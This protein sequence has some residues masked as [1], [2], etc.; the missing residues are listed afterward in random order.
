MRTIAFVR[1][2]GACDDALL[3]PVDMY[4]DAA[5]SLG[6]NIGSDAIEIKLLPWNSAGYL[7]RK[8]GAGVRSKNRTAGIA[9]WF[10]NTASIA[11]VD[12]TKSLQQLNSDLCR[13]TCGNS[14][15]SVTLNVDERAPK[16]AAVPEM[17]K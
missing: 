9:P 3:V 12:L 7:T 16:M 13:W 17:S 10:V 4:S 14:L 5:S 8:S 2:P 1:V 11:A 15:C 6:V